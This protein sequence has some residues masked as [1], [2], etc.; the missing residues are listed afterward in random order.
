MHTFALYA[1]FDLFFV[2]LTR[3][4]FFRNERKKPFFT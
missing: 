1:V 4:F 2:V 3:F